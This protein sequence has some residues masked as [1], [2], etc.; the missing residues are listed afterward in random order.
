[1]SKVVEDGQVTEPTDLEPLSEPLE[2]R[3]EPTEQKSTVVESESDLDFSIG[4]ES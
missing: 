1:M 2:L 4:L 3:T